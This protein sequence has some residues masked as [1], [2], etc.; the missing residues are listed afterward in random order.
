MKNHQ[1]ELHFWQISQNIDGFRQQL[2]RLLEFIKQN[3]LPYLEIFFFL[4]YLPKVYFG[5]NP[6]KTGGGA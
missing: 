6:K 2:T 1:R 3:S 4:H 5:F